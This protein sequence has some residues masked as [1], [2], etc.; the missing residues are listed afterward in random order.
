MKKSNK[1]ETDF[2]KEITKTVNTAKT[3]YID[4][5]MHWCSI[6]NVE[7][8]SVFDVIKRNRKLKLGLR[9]SAEDLNLIKKEAR[10]NRLKI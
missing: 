4:A 3:D 2:V 8:E 1:N 10:T 5:I 6:N 9:N 7:I